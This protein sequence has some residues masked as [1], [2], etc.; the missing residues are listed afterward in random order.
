MDELQP[1]RA[2]RGGGEGLRQAAPVVGHGQ[3]KLLAIDLQ[4]HA[5]LAA[6]VGAIRVGQRVGKQFVEDQ[7]AGYGA[8]DVQ[9]HATRAPHCDC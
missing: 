1:Q 4:P 7:S 2:G 9:I 5:D 8:I 3:D 6:L